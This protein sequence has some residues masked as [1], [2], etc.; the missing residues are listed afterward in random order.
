MNNG[1]Y[2]AN[3][4]FSMLGTFWNQYFGDSAFIGSLEGG[5]QDQG[6]QTYFEFIQRVAAVSRFEIPVFKSQYWYFLTLKQSEQ[7]SGRALVI[8]Y[9]DTD[10]AY[11]DGSIYGGFG[12]PKDY[13]FEIDPTL[14]SALAITNRVTDASLLWM[15]GTDFEFEDDF[16]I[17][18]DSPFDNDLIPKRTIVDENGVKVDEEVGLWLYMGQ[19]DIEW[20]WNQFGF[21]VQLWLE[22]SEAYKEIVNILYDMKMFG[23]TDLWFRTILGTMS[24]VLS[25]IEPT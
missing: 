10:L 24:G 14:K 7:N 21:A 18:K 20:V 1:F 16:I 11:G 15:N 25:I 9:G 12:K 5:I 17:F 22:S 2:T 6:A 3:S 4:L 19:W 13:M 23:C 8:K